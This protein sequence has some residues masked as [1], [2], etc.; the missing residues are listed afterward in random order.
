M[1]YSYGQA[2]LYAPKYA[3]HRRPRTGAIHNQMDANYY[4]LNEL[5]EHIG[6]GEINEILN[7]LYRYYPDDYKE[8][9]L[10]VTKARKK[11]IAALLK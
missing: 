8:L 9:S 1:R 11:E 6:T 3:E 2:I 5:R 10:L 4:F 7:D